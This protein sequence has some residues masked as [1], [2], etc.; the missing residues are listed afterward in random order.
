VRYPYPSNSTSLNVVYNRTHD[1][2]NH[3]IVYY[4]NLSTVEYTSKDV[5]KR[6]GAAKFTESSKQLSAWADEMIEKY[7]KTATDRDQDEVKAT[8]FGPEAHL[9]ESDP[10]YQTK[11]VT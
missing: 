8:G 6:L 3:F 2:P 4:K 1:G 9:D 10:N 7:E 5:R 11:M